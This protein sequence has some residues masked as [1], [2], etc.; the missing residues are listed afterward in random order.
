MTCTI[1][2]VA[3]SET[4]YREVFEL[5]LEE[6]REVSHIRLSP[7]KTA[8]AAY[9]VIAEGM[10]FLARDADG[11]PIGTLGLTE[12]E[13]WFADET[14]L[15]DRWFYVR[16]AYRANGVG[17]ALIRAAK[18]E[19]TRLEKIVYLTIQNP[20]RRA[21]NHRMML[22]SQECGFVPFGYTIRIR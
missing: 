20:D 21:K 3:I 1:E 12:L 19:A 14:F 17:S 11:T 22:E 9:R 4:T 16:P 8:Q 18:D 13:Y 5:L 10:T 7:E 15:Q 2:R 6:Y